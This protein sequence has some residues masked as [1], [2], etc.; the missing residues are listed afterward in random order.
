MTTEDELNEM[1]KRVGERKKYSSGASFESEFA[2]S[3]VVVDGRWVWVS[4]TTGYDY[5]SMT[6]SPDAATQATQCFE[7]IK[8]ALAQ[9]DATLADVVRVTYL[10]PDRNDVTAFAPVF[11]RY[12]SQT[13][14]AATLLVTQLLNTDMK[15]EIEVTA[16]KRKTS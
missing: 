3:R 6:I 5:R 15:I 4:G 1:N 12:L 13:L 8:V 14:P 10:V 7:N 9:A 16:L 11:K 2:Y